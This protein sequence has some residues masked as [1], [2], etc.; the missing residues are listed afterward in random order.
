MVDQRRIRI[1]PEAWY[2]ALVLALLLSIGIMREANLLLLVAGLLCGP[3]FLGWR[4]A[5]RTLRDLDVRRRVPQ[6]ICAGDLLVVNL[7]LA[8]RRKRLPSWAV[9][10]EDRLIPEGASLGNGPVQPRAYFGH[11]PAGGACHQ[12]YRGRIAQRGRYRL[13]PMTVWTRFPFGFFRR[14][15]RLNHTETLTVL[16]RLGRLKPGWAVPLDDCL[17]GARRPQIQHRRGLG[18]FYG[19]RQWRPGESRRWIHWRSSARHGT[20][21]VCQIQRHQQLNVAVLVDLWQPRQSHVEHFEN[22]ELAVSFAATVVADVSRQAGSSLLLGIASA[23][24]DLLAGPVSTPLMHQAMERLAL[25]K[26]HSGDQLRP[27]LDRVGTRLGPDTDVILV[28]TR[29]VDL[30]EFAL[31]PG[32]ADDFRPG[33]TVRRLRVVNTSD[34]DLSEIFQVQ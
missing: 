17:E 9:V 20:L 8:N 23:D 10:V 5:V 30:D 3:L 27:L 22:V 1:C 19:V 26:G 31:A 13:G 25:A 2:Y 6:A 15:I 11:I 34:P 24:P 28:T 33:S 18:D 29:S 21:V 4:L 32:S 14:S 12:F 7:D 16:P